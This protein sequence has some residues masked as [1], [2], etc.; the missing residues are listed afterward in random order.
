MKDQPKQLLAQRGT[1]LVA[2]A[3][4]Y[5]EIGTF[6]IQVAAKLGQPAVKLADGAWFYPHFHVENSDAAGTLLV[7]FYQGRVS[8]LALVTPDVALALQKTANQIRVAER[9]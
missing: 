8:W 1:V 3:G 5:V 4:P 2:G 6:Q 7:R 9:K